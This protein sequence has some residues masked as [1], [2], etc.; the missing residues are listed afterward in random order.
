MKGDI[1]IVGGGTAGWFAAAYLSR[2]FTD[3][4]IILVES[5][6]VPKIGVGESVTPH[7]VDFVTHELGLDERKWMKET[8]AI[9]KLGNRFID[10]CHKGHSEYFSFT[11]AIPERFAIGRE[12]VTNIDDMAPDGSPLTTDVFLDLYNK[13]YFNK[14]DKFF[15]SQYNWMDKQKFHEDNI[16][17]I[18]GVS[19]HIN[20]DETTE[21]VKN[22][23]GIPNGV[24]HIEDDVID[25]GVKEDRV[26]YI[27]TKYHSRIES[28]Y[29]VDSTGFK[30]LLISKLNVKTKDYNYPINKAI[31]GRSEYTDP[32]KEMKNYTQS[33]AEDWGW[34]FKVTLNQRVGN[35]FCFSDAHVSDTQAWDFFTNK[36]KAEPRFIKWNTDRLEEPCKGN[37]IC[38]GLSNGFI[39]PLEANNLFIIVESILSL[40]KFLKHFYKTGNEDHESFNLKTK[41]SF[42]NIRDF[43]LVHY[44][45]VDKD[46]SE[47]WKDMCDIGVKENHVDYVYEKYKDKNCNMI[48]AINGETLFPEYMWLQFAISWGLDVSKW[49]SKKS[50]Y[51]LTKAFTFFNSNYMSN[52]VLSSQY[53]NYYKAHNKWIQ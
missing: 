45:L 10:W 7:V 48:A 17:S 53:D 40:G 21:Y 38:V 16:K 2:Q 43:L 23:I 28:D 29:F 51:S 49:V 13:G 18:Y 12:E 8:G 11:Y 20:A 1:C 42:D 31:V 24:I 52:Y 30:R 32:S 22:N 6:N 39:E 41:I 50:T 9:F 27:D 35:G 44:T 46:R 34:S 5:K 37:V 25:V 3:K 36:F 4:K 26:S 47:F 14:F 19:H 33:I 15:H